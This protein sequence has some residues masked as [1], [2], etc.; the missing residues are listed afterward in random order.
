MKEGIVE[1]TMSEWDRMTDEDKYDF[2]CHCGCPYYFYLSD[3][4]QCMYDSSEFPFDTERP[5]LLL[6]RK[7][8]HVKDS[9]E[10]SGGH[11]W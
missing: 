10:L 3:V 11:L 9:T 8:R 7:D 6:K 4:N 1:R 5:C 2:C